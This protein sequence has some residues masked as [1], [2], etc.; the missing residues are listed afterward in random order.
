MPFAS[1]NGSKVEYFETGTGPGLVLVHG[2]GGDAGTYDH[3]RD[4]FSD[5]R[6]VVVPNYSGSGATEDEG[7][8][9]TLDLL[10]EQI[11]AAIED[12]SAEG[13]VDLLGWSQGA[14]AVA[15]FAAKHPE[16]VRR[17]V[18]L[19]GWIKNDARQELFFDLWDRLDKLDHETFGRFLQ[20]N[21]WTTTQVNALGV[22]GVEEMVSGGIPAGIGRQIA[23]NLELDLT[24]HLPRIT[25]PTLVI[26]ATHDRMI[27]VAHSRELH[28]AIKGS[29]YA[30]LDAG[31]FAVFEKPAELAALVEE[32]LEEDAA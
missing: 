26:G 20:L 13:P 8:P 14:L 18:L 1:T 32:F 7:G 22:A 17:L 10:V 2:T 21:G 30:E 29:R 25:A 6:T 27:P 9:L 11:G 31:H 3:L 24:D 5:R 12:S 15:A 23:L 16:K 4:T 28:A 19:A